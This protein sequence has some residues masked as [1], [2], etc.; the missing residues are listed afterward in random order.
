MNN[1]KHKHINTHTHMDVLTLSQTHKHAHACMH[2][3]THTQTYALLRFSHQQAF[4]RKRGTIQKATL[5]VF[6]KIHPYLWGVGSDLCPTFDSLSII[7]QMSSGQSVLLPGA[8]SERGR[9]AFSLILLT[10]KWNSTSI[11][12]AAPHRSWPVSFYKFIL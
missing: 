5:C 6:L 1:D 10:L 9:W 7:S 12:P 2:T 3:H 8:Q 11:L 4:S